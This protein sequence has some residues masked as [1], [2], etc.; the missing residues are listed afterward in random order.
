M[1]H[2]PLLT[3]TAASIFMVLVAVVLCVMLVIGPK[4]THDHL[5]TVAAQLAL[6]HDFERSAR[7]VVRAAQDDGAGLEP[8]LA[9]LQANRDALDARTAALLAPQAAGGAG[10]DAAVLREQHAVIA[11][12]L[13][14]ARV[15]WWLTLALAALL[16]AGTLALTWQVRHHVLRPLGAVNRLLDALALGKPAPAEAVA[17]QPALQ[18]AFE[19][20]NTLVRRTRACEE[21]RERC[22]A[23]VR[24]DVRNATRELMQQQITLLREQHLA[25]YGELCARIAHDMRNPLAGIL[26][27]VGNLQREARD[28]EQHARLGLISD[29]VMRLSRQ[30]DGLVSTWRR[31]PEVPTELRVCDSAESVLALSSY[32]LPA[33]MELGCDV[34]PELTLRLPE[35]GFKQALLILITTAAHAM[36]RSTAGGISIG[37]SVTGEH[38]TVTV[39]DSGPGF[40]DDALAAGAHA[41]GRYSA[42]G[43]SSGLGLA[44]VR[45]FVLDQGG[46]IEVGNVEGGG[47]FVS[48]K[49]PQSLAH[50]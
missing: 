28:D 22:E 5:Q 29:E 45:R 8:A 2:R 13:R 48:L 15:G 34:D 37:S 18:P 47:G 43:S 25:E 12:L 26:A 20:Y 21:D 32:H 44:A 39:R 50:G 31:R 35:H 16:A 42:S 33:G 49:F 11:E 3:L 36:G 10:P 27:A 24:R 41:F 19:S 17:G 4:R 23:D 1:L 9:R 14:K 6:L 40:S 46:Q 30:L 38:V 7:A